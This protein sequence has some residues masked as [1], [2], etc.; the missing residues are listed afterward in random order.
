LLKVVN[1]QSYGPDVVEL[2]GDVTRSAQAP[3][4]LPA[5]KNG[6]SAKK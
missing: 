1:S 3:A 2:I 5:A 4:P 6:K